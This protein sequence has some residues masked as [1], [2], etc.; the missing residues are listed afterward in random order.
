MSCCIQS[1]PYGPGVELDENADIKVPQI[2]QTAHRESLTL[3]VSSTQPFFIDSNIDPALLGGPGV[4]SFL[5]YAPSEPLQ[6]GEGPC[7]SGSSKGKS[8]LVH[9]TQKEP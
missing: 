9:Q 5:G 1:H 4:A 7:T 8:T 6:I 3:N 2:D